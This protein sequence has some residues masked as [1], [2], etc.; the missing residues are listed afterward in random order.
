M[1]ADDATHQDH[2][3]WVA[4]MAITPRFDHGYH[5]ESDVDCRDHAVLQLDADE[6]A[7]APEELVMQEP[8]DEPRDAASPSEAVPVAV[9]V[10]MLATE[11]WSL[12]ATR[13]MIWNEIFTRTGM[14]LTTLSAAAVAIALVAQA[15][16]FGQNFRVFSLLVL[17][18]VLL[19]GIGTVIRLGSALEEDFL[20]VAGMNR[21]RRAYLDIAPD[22]EPYFITSALDDI[23][24]ILQSAVAYGRPITMRVTPGRVLSS[25]AA[26]VG[27]LDCVL[28]GII[29]AL[30]ADLID[31]R[32]VVYVSAGVIAALAGALVVIGVVPYRSI[33]RARREYQ[34]RFPGP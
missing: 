20:L 4:R 26:I 17:P 14:F 7:P 29:A 16:D 3:W 1:K 8:P 2:S 30:L 9:R 12:L 34:P 27:I 32:A 25:S 13:S 19:L 6:P 28:L 22:L 10:Q 11:H 33:A 24:G 23:P 21:L 15:N 5:V 18:V 31:D